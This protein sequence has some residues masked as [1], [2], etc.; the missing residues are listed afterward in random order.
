MREDVGVWVKWTE[1]WWSNIDCAQWACVV[2]CTGHSHRAGLGALLTTMERVGCAFRLEEMLPPAPNPFWPQLPTTGTAYI[3]FLH[4]CVLVSGLIFRASRSIA[5]HPFLSWVSLR[6]STGGDCPP[7]TANMAANK[8][9]KLVCT[10]HA[11]FSILPLT[12][13]MP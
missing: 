5:A 11:L 6:T 2:A 3:H 4:P 1:L 12:N 13:N 9:G 10:P 7:S 8:Q